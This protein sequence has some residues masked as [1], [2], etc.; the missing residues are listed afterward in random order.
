MSATCSAAAAAIN[1]LTS[2]RAELEGGAEHKQ[3][4][5]GGQHGGG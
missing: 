3:H 1:G 4:H 2:L 5:G